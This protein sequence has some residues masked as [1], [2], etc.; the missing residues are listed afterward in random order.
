M[1]LQVNL[2]SS[3]TDHNFDSKIDIRT[4]DQTP[5]V[6]LANDWL[7]MAKSAK[8]DYVE[9]VLWKRPQ[10]ALTTINVEQVSPFEI[11]LGEREDILTGFDDMLA[12]SAWP[13]SLHE[14]VEQDVR[15]CL[16]AFE[17]IL[18]GSHY[19][20]RLQAISDD[21]CCKFHQDRTFQ[22]L[23]ITYRGG[24]TVWRDVNIAVDQQAIEMECVLLRG[25]RAN[26][27]PQILHR[28]PVFTKERLPR[29]IMVIDVIPSIYKI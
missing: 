15:H 22:R 24:G 12:A 25:K 1:T 19:R 29:L 10:S 20:L 21:A 5:Y 17:T 27:E 3:D 8:N 6:R 4:R 9:L 7:D 14:I 2:S 16:E 18:P 11:L 28:S 26:R 23:I 13:A